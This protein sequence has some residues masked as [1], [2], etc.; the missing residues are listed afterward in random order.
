MD[1]R[2]LLLV[3]LLPCVALAAPAPKKQAAPICPPKAPTPPPP[4]LNWSVAVVPKANTTNNGP[5]LMSLVGQGPNIAVLFAGFKVNL[6]QT[7]VWAEK[8]G[9]EASPKLTDFKVGPLFAVPGPADDGFRAREIDVVGIARAVK[10]AADHYGAKLVIFGAHSSGAAV[11]EATLVALDKQAPSLMGKTVYY[12]LDGGGGLPGPTK[13]KLAG[14]FCAVTKCNSQK[15]PLLAQNGGACSPEFKKLVLD[16]P[17][18]CQSAGCCH[19]ALINTS[20]KTVACG[21]PNDYTTF[22]ATSRPNGMWLDQTRA[23]LSGLAGP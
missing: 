6:Q 15:K 1:R 8:L 23:L 14:S 11:A 17:N 21:D 16:T 12:R 3:S 18:A 13:K 10:L 2:A 19:V 7:V 4:A 20:P 22:D 9:T 5:V